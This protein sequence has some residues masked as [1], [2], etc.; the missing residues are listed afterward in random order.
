MLIIPSTIACCPILN[1]WS[2]LWPLLCLTEEVFLLGQRLL[3]IVTRLLPRSINL[4][5]FAN[6]YLSLG[7]LTSSGALTSLGAAHGPILLLGPFI[8]TASKYKIPRHKFR[9]EHNEQRR[10][11]CSNIHYHIHIQFTN[12]LP[13]NNIYS[14]FLILGFIWFLLTKSK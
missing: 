7:Y 1:E 4:Y 11:S 6:I 13:I 5:A 8:P 3:L 9:S 10:G 12:S 2:D 14:G